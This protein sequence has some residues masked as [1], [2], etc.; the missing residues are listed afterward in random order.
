VVLRHR[1][2]FRFACAFLLLYRISVGRKWLTFEF[3]TCVKSTSYDLIS[4]FVSKV[5][6]ERVAKSVFQT[7]S[8]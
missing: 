3:V 7:S 6:S 1:G 2:I 4:A 5:Q 8:L